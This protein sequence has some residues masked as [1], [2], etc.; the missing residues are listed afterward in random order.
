[1]SAADSALPP[2][3]KRNIGKPVAVVFETA[4]RPADAVTLGAMLL[5][6]LAIVVPAIQK[7]RGGSDRQQCGENLRR[8]VFAFHKYHDDPLRLP[9][10]GWNQLPI[11]SPF[12]FDCQGIGPFAACLKYLEAEPLSRQL[13]TT[14]GIQPVRA[15][16]KPGFDFGLTSVSRHWT[17]SLPNL[18]LAEARIP[19]LRCPADASDD[20][21]PGVGVFTIMGTQG[22]TFTG[23]YLPAP[24]G[25][26][27]GGTNYV[28]LCGGFQTTDPF[29]GTWEGVMLNR[30]DLSL[31]NIAALDGL[32]NTAMIGEWV[33]GRASGA[34]LGDA[35]SDYG[36]SWMAGVC[37]PTAWGVWPAAEAR[38][39]ALSSRHSNVAQIGY[40]DGSVRGIRFVPPQ[41]FFTG[42]W[43]ILM[44]I[45]GRQDAGMRDAPYI[46]D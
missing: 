22:L 39:W 6:L 17:T 32:G 10:G 34:P 36:V 41:P 30:G 15:A 37:F 7:A 14:A 20:E 45:S 21:P 1:M 31:G 27:L 11:D 5:V 3:P 18:T 25:G 28:P 42:P 16:G 33:G 40:C 19:W 13:R 24:A 23:G 12:S 46:P 4:I 26:R 44:E 8:I 43:H 2:P 9:P 38:W 29:Y 35:R